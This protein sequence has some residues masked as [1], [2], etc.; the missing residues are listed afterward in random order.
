MTDKHLPAKYKV[1]KLTWKKLVT[2]LYKT[3]K[4]TEKEIKETQ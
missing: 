2:F 3:Y 4:C 1:T